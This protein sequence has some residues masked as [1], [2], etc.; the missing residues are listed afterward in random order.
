MSTKQRQDKIIEILGKEGYVTVKYLSDELHYSSATINRDLNALEKQ[1]LVSRS[2]GGVEL[3]RAAYVPVNFRAHKMRIE[4]KQISRL[5]ASFVK[6]GDTIFVDGST[7]AQCMET[8][9]VNKKGLT[10]VTNNIM[11]AMDLSGYDVR[12]V[13]LGGTVVEPPCM[14]YGAE[15]VENAARYRVD[16][17]FFSTGAVTSGGVI[18]SGIYDLVLKKVAENAGEIYYLVDHKKI[19]Q[20]FNTIYGDF[21]RVD[22]VVSD[23]DFPDETK[24]KYPN[25]RFVSID[26]AVN[27]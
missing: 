14:L 9:L 21:S 13:C 23:Y 15:T 17:M 7:T 25:A 26:K 1:R 6:D 2:Y 16:K 11:L 20:P 3:V 8:Y 24:R 10:V 5:A 27:A 18:A 4:K 22:V 19:D 12:V